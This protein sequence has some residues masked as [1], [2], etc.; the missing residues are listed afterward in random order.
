MYSAKILN[1]FIAFHNHSIHLHIVA[2]CTEK[3]IL[4][5]RPA[6]VDREVDLLFGLE[7]LPALPPAYGEGKFH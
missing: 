2:R 7:S 1:Y 3:M 5:W 4:T 6:L